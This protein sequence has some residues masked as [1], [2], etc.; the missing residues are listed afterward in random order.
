VYGSLVPVSSADAAL[1]K[2]ISGKRNAILHKKLT[3]E[4][5]VDM[6]LNNRLQ[7]SF[8][9]SHDPFQ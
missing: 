8:W 2:Y 9:L 3:I 6:D 5:V 7:L 4:I 1:R